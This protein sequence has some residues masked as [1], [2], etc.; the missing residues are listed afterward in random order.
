M[1][2]LKIIKYPGIKGPDGTYKFKSIKLPIDK[3]TFDLLFNSMFLWWSP[4]LD[5]DLDGMTH[6]IEDKLSDVF[7]IM[8]NQIIDIKLGMTNG[9]DFEHLEVDATNNEIEVKIEIIK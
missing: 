1:Y 4:E 3:K 2:Y 5:R 6:E 9:E 7:Y 8:V